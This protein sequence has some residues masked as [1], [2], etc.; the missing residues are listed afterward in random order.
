MSRWTAFSHGLLFILGFSAI[1]IG[2]GGLVFT[3]SLGR[4]PQWGPLIEL[5][6]P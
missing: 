5:G 6:A 2:L 3:N 1:F 4:L